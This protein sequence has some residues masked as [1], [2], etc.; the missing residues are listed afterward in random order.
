MNTKSRYQ[1][2]LPTQTLFLVGLIIGLFILIPVLSVRADGAGYALEFDGS[3]DFVELAQTASIMG[4]GWENTKSVSMWV[5]PQGPTPVCGNPTPAWCDAVFGDRPRWWGISRG[6]INGVD[7]IWV[8]NVDGS[9][10][11][12]LDQI[13]IDYT[14]GEWVHIVMVH[15]GGRLYAYRNG[16]LVGDIASGTTLQ[17]NTGARPMLQLGGVINSD[18]RNWTFEGQL[19]E[20]R[21]WNRVRTVEEINQDMYQSLAGNESGLMAYYKMS[22]GAG[23]TLTD[24]SVNSWNG[25]LRDGLESVLVPPDGS[26]PEWVESSAFDIQ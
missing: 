6:A 17:P 8:W 10:D 1:F 7:K 19:D 14:S 12:G 24:D 18:T 26:P 20:V 22:D 25:I 23:L 9:P 15:S 11:S 4:A 21:I 5:K 3:N 16:E 13:G 2:T